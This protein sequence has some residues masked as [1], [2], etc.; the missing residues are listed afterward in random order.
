MRIT[1]T[2][3]RQK[4]IRLSNLAKGYRIREIRGLSPADADIATTEYALSN[5][6]MVTNRR[7]P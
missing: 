2:N 4:K 7:I 6:S 3:D 1:L 5:G